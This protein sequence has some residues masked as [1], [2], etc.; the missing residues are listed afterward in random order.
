MLDAFEPDDAPDSDVPPWAGPGVAAPVRSPRRAARTVGTEPEYQADVAEEE[1]D[2][3]LPVPTRRRPGRSRAAATRRRR[4]RRRLVTW[5]S[6]AAVTVVI[7]GLV[8][9]LVQP[10]PRPSP[11]VSHLQKGEFASVPNACQVMPAS[12]LSQYLGGTAGKNVQ[13]ASGAQKSECTFQ[14]DTKPMFRVLDITVQAYTPNLIAPGNGS[15]TSYAQYT[16]AQTKQMLVKPPKHTLAPPATIK[17]VPGLGTTAFSA[18]QV[19]HGKARTERATVLVQFR[20]V[21]ATVSLWATA[22]K[23]FGP[24]PASQLLADAVGAARD[25]LTKV[26]A[27]PSVGA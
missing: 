18:L 21:M 25:V 1:P 26:K 14:V 10:T 22:S 7:A 17:P 4:S 6:V 9:I 15:A 3:D 27:V 12:L 2:A 8:F 20:N 11:Y 5:G 24:V 13:T 19:Y 23:G 16:F